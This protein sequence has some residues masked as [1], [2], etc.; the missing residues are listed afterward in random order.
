[1]L[2][3]ENTLQ[4]PEFFGFVFPFLELILD[5]WHSRRLCPVF[6]SLLLKLRQAKPTRFLKQLFV[7]RK[8][9]PA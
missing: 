4:Q 8:E 3:N 5:S 7:L 1:M 9:V 6:R 2:I